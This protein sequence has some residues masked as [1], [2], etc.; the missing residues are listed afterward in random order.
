[1]SAAATVTAAS[2]TAAVVS[3]AM[4]MVAMIFRPNLKSSVE[5]CFCHFPD[6]SFRSANHKNICLSKSI[7]SSAADS[8]ANQK[9]YFFF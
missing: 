3:I 8:A 6:I 2:V 5:K 1:M 9:I 7:D 4:M